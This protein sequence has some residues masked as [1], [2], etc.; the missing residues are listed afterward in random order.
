MSP[1]LLAKDASSSKMSAIVKG[2]FEGFFAFLTCKS[3]WKLHVCINIYT[4]Y[5]PKKTSW[6]DFS[7][8]LWGIFQLFFGSRLCIRLYNLCSLRDRRWGISSFKSRYTQM[9]T[10]ATHLTK[11]NFF[12]KII[13]Y[14]KNSVIR[15]TKKIEYTFTAKK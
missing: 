5:F 13:F 1:W 14:V 12:S 3:L 9:H 8:F 10:A 6:L 7:K 11:V 4:Y 2:H 15:W